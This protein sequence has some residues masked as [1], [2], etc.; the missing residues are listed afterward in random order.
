MRYTE[1]IWEDLTYKEKQIY[2]LYEAFQR[3]TRKNGQRNIW[4]PQANS[5]SYFI[6]E[7]DGRYPGDKIREAKNWKYFKELYEIYQNDKLFDPHTFMEAIFRRLRKNSSYFPSR[8]NTKLNRNYYKEYR[9]KLKMSSHETEE[10]KIMRDFINTYK[11]IS[12]RLNKSKLK[13]EDLYQFFNKIKDNSIISDGVFCS[14][15]KMVSPFY[16]VLSKS[17]DKAYFNSDKDIQEEIINKERFQHLRGLM[18]L[19]TKIYKF[20]RQVFK[21]DII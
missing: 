18:R 3:Q 10:K 6:Y 17:F 11:F 4:L 8:L 12:K 7:R 2:H 15:Q 9:M 20:A 19:K 1:E 16:L 13:Q 21:E 5:K 14:I